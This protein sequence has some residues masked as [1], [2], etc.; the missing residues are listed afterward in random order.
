MHVKTYVE[1][2]HAVHHALLLAVSRVEK[3]VAR[4]VHQN[5]RHHAQTY[6]QIHVL[7]LVAAHAGLI[8]RHLVNLLA[9]GAHLHALHRVM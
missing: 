4:L 9:S 5:A 3:L 7:H 8:V 1:E 2:T 6:A